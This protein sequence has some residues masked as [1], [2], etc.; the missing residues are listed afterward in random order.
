MKLE[1]TENNVIKKPVKDDTIS[2]NEING[3]IKDLFNRK[4]LENYIKKNLG[5][6]L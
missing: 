4:L 6:K 1:L 5:T 3:Y 2:I